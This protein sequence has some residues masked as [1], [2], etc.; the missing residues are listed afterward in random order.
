MP[1]TLRQIQ[2]FVGTAETGQISQAANQL[3]ISQSA[4]TIAIRQLEAAL[5]ASLFIRQPNGMVL[6]ETGQHFLTHAYEILRS[7]DV[8]LEIRHWDSGLSGTL[9]LAAT[10]TIM[11]YFL[12]AKLH[13]FAKLY[14]NIHI[15]LN[16]LSRSEIECGLL[17]GSIDLAV[18]ISSN[19]KH[20]DI[21]V[22]HL[23]DSKRQLWLSP[24]HALSA[25]EV[26]DLRDLANEDYVMLT[27]DE[28]ANV[29][30]QYWQH[31]DLSPKVLLRTASIEA[32]RSM[33][34]YNHGITILSDM[35]Y[36]TWSLERK[37]IVRIPILPAP[38]GMG[39][40]LAWQKNRR[41]NAR[42]KV[43]CDYLIQHA[44]AA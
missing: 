18:L 27:V 29:A 2:Y 5:G 3:N 39:I 41:L 14:P 10:Y 11:S 4:I 40:G 23:F 28:A 17:D 34:G 15:K 32:V 24:E 33:V 36:R 12:P 8:A 35:V 30:E 9:N 42:E 44:T 25:R 19:V 7:V 20:E 37:R 6:T 31:N 21:A 22:R 16:E 43:F 1:I 38:P 26:V 13:N